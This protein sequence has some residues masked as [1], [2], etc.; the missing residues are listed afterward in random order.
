M[1]ERYEIGPA[2]LRALA[3]IVGL[4][5]CLTSEVELELYGY[6]SSHFFH[7]P[8]VV[9]SPGDVTQTRQLVALCRRSGWPLTCRGAGTSL[10]GGA[11]ARRGGV[12]MST[13][14]LRKIESIDL[15]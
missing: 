4:E 10:S 14:R 3:D 2:G 7:R 11:V 13:A 15:L 1:S 12:L 5:Y 8:G 9:V 6:D